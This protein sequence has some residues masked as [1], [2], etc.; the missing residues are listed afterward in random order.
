MHAS[1]RGGVP[2]T[3]ASRINA[4]RVLEAEFIAL[5][6]AAGQNKFRAPSAFI[7]DFSFV[8]KDLPKLERF[9]VISGRIDLVGITLEIYGPTP[10]QQNPLPVSIN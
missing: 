3:E 10:T 6:A 4:P 8:N 2:Q 7:R 9:V 1:L 5:A